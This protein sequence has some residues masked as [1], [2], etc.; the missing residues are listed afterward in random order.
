MN[1]GWLLLTFMV[2]ELEQN[3]K[4]FYSETYKNIKKMFDY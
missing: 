2:T 1:K 3:I 4:Y